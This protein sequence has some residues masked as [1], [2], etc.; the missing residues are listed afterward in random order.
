MIVVSSRGAIPTD[1][2][3]LGSVSSRLAADAPCPVLIVGSGR[4]QEVDPD[5][6]AGRTLVCGLDGSRQACS[7]ALHAADL[8]A[9]LEGPL[10]AV[11]VETDPDVACLERVRSRLAG[12]R[13]HVDIDVRGGD[14][15]DVI[16]RVA[17]AAT[18]PLI[19]V[20]SRGLGPRSGDLLGPVCTSLLRH[21]RRPV[22]VTP[23]TT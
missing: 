6:W 12:T 4:E 16:E 11:A 17:A 23:T 8:A 14:P 2:A 22:L 15:A 13:T 21:A 10:L 9:A 19:A 5:Q 20:G 3:L 18:A 1:E 7:A